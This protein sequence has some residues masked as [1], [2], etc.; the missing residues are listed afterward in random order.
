MEITG[1]SP[2]TFQLVAGFLRIRGGGNP[3]D[4]TAVHPD[5]YDIVEKIADS[6]KVS[7]SDL[8]SNPKLIENVDI[9]AFRTE[10]AGSYTLTDIKEEL[11]KPGRDPRDT[12][13]LP[14]FRD[15]VKEIA[16]L[17]PGMQLEGVITNVT[18]FGSFVDISFH[19]DGLVH[20]SELSNRFIKDPAEFVKAGQ[21]VK[22]QVLTADPKTKRVALSMKA[23]EPKPAGGAGGGGGGP[24]PPQKGQ[25][26][27]QQPAK[28]SLEDQIAALI[29]KFRTR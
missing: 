12:F 14:S 5:A 7:L 6:L 28:K 19:H 1:L 16:D 22:V 15:D 29:S 3:L 4:V 27:K 17:K 25:P 23:C 18:R 21:I 9:Q 13:Q 10:Q 2:E 26:P 20:V 11:R 8:I 24:R